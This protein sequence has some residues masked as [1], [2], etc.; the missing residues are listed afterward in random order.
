MNIVKSAKVVILIFAIV[1]VFIIGLWIGKFWQRPAVTSSVSTQSTNQNSN[2]EQSK[3]SA[4]QIE[5]LTGADRAGKQLSAGHC[6]GTDKPK[7]THLP[8]DSQDFGFILP[9]G[10]MIGGHVTPVDHQYFSPI[11]FD[12]KP[13]T[14]N[15]YAMADSTLVGVST[16]QHLGQGQNKNITVTDYRLVFSVS[17]RL[18]YYYD[19]INSLAPGLEEKFNDPAN[20]S[21]V[22]VT[23]GDL[24]GK[25]GGQTLDF[26]VWDTEKPLSGF[27]VPKR[28]EG[29]AWKIYTAD[30]LD[31][32]TDDVKAQALAKYVRMQEPRSGKIDYDQDGKLIGNWFQVGTNGYA[33]PIGHGESG[34]WNGHLSISPYFLDPNSFLISIGNWPSQASQ[35]AAKESGP[36][37]AMVDPDTGLVKYNLV[38]YRNYVSSGLQWDNMTLPNSPISMHK[39]SSIQGCILLEMMGPR[40]LK[41]QAF[42]G[43]GCASVSG[44]TADAT[45]YER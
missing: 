39:L 2:A 19:L 42:K 31:Y 14:Y 26:A 6:T 3:V 17:C 10:L 5:Q 35:F 21:G 36:D 13:S 15:V 25:I 11:V 18:L 4:T 27:V 33:G 12:S 43:K 45:M 24:I 41:A 8:M 37:P 23:S 30:P 32:Y 9:Y 1:L 16:R 29:E 28:Y 22:R 20:S 44:F 34:Y 40:S 38:E 7:L